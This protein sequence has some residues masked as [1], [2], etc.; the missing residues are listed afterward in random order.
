MRVAAIAVVFLSA[1]ILRILP[2]APAADGPRV[3][4]ENLADFYA[5]SAADI[6][7]ARALLYGLSPTDAGMVAGATGI[8]AV[9]G[10][11]AASIPAW[12]AARVRLA[13]A[14][15]SE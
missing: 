13:D 14:M 8:L 15:R 4:H 6:Q 9:A 3:D 2:A 10:V 5:L 12:R 7:A 11:L 1:G